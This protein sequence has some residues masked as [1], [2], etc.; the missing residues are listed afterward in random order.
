MNLRS[1]LAS[2]EKRTRA[3]ESDPAPAPTPQQKQLIQTFRTWLELMTPD[4]QKRFLDALRACRMTVDDPL[5]VPGWR[6]WIGLL[7]CGHGHAWPEAIPTAMVDVF[8]AFPMVE[9]GTGCD[10]CH[11]P[12]LKIYA[13]DLYQP[14]ERFRFGE[15]WRDFFPNCPGCGKDIRGLGHPDSWYVPLRPEERQQ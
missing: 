7:D 1:R 11:L 4:D 9:L 12:Q 10:S 3:A 5:K 13:P 2:L 14:V 8:L 15:T 6:D